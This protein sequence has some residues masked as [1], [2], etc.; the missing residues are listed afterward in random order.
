MP[1]KI[2]N[3]DLPAVADVPGGDAMAAAVE[4]RKARLAKAADADAPKLR[5]A[6]KQLKR[7]QRKLRKARIH[8]SLKAKKPAAAAEG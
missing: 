5:A 1:K 2:A 8:T 7:A 3:K 6:H 4:R